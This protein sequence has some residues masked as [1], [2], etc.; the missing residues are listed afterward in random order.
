M[1]VIGLTGSIGMGKSTV[2][3]QFALLGVRV[4]NADAIVHQ[5]MTKNGAAVAEIGKH[6]PT[7]IKNVAVD[8]KALGDIVFKDK[9]KL[10]QL[11]KI[12][13][14]LVIAAENDFIRIEQC[15]GAWAAVLEIPLLFETGAEERCDCVAVVTAPDFIQRQRVLMRSG[16]TQEKLSRILALQITDREKRQCAD[17]V[18]NT[19]IGKAYSFHQVKTWLQQIR[20]VA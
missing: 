9:Q 8:R 6:F 18:I 3:S 15:K 7:A 17:I 4:C 11:E 12:L 19:G 14:P 16:M 20:S 1:I 13:H 5:L 2:A 10:K